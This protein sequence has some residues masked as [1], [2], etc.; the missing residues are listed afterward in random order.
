MNVYKHVEMQCSVATITVALL[1]N[2]TSHVINYI[3]HE[4][5]IRFPFTGL[6][7]IAQAPSLLRK[8][9]LLNTKIKQIL[10]TEIKPNAI[11]NQLMHR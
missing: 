8:T 4:H 11:C 9:T 6:S 5:L 7:V 2:F 3:K 10:T 1:T